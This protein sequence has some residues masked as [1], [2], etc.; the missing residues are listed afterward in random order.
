MTMPSQETETAI[1]DP[2]QPPGGWAGPEQPRLPPRTPQESGWLF[3]LV[4]SLARAFGRRQLPAVFPLLHHHPGLFWGWLHF[5]ARMMPWGRLPA[6][7]RE[8]LILR[9]A[10]RCRSRYEWGQHVEIALRCGVSDAEI[11]AMARGE[12]APRPGMDL[13]LRACDEL[14]DAGWLADDTWQALHQ[15]LRPRELIELMML[16]GHYRMLAGVLI[17]CGLPL[18]ADMERGLAAFHTRVAG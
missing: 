10:W 14:L 2:L 12:P 3:R 15:R 8:L 18:D 17:S 16:V 4:G 11:V 13:L 5:A 7:E 6:A 1:V 9:T